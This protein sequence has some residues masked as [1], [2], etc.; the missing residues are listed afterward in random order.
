ML[1]AIL[2]LVVGGWVVFG[3]S[4]FLGDIHSPKQSSELRIVPVNPIPLYSEHGDI[5]EFDEPIGDNN[6]EIQLVLDSH[7]K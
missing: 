7:G 3:S 6:N 5:A 4:H 1:S 2:I